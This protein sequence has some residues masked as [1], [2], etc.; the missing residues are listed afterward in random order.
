[1]PRGWPDAAGCRRATSS[2]WVGVNDDDRASLLSSAS[3]YVAPQIG[4]ESFGIV[5]V[6]AM[7]AA[8]GGGERSAAFR[9]VLDGGALGELFDIGDPV[10]LARAVS[11]ALL[12]D[13]PAVRRWQ[14]P[15]ARC[16]APATTG[17]SGRRYRG[18]L[19]R[20]RCRLAEQGRLMDER[21]RLA[22]RAAAG[23]LLLVVLR[24]GRSWTA[25]R[26]D[27]LHLRR[28]GG[29]GIPRRP[30]PASVR[31]S[32]PAR[33]AGGLRSGLGPAA[34][35]GRRDTPRESDDR[36]D[37]EQWLAESELTATLFVLDLPSPD[38]EPLVAELTHAARKAA[39]PAGSTTMSPRRPGD[40]TARRRVR[41]FRLAGHAR[42][43]G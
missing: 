32:R 36:G 37:A 29:P 6:E 4:G 8:P 14:C 11:D 41:G 39:S 1:M 28:R 38:Q 42:R 12:D 25:G 43:R 19:R 33:R 27:R 15:G 31:R 22:R 23:G 3:V 7:A 34:A 35:R 16:R 26:L 24:I 21:Q 40:C 30:A 9:A 17:A 18:G 20:C 10:D 2:S 13:P 5:L